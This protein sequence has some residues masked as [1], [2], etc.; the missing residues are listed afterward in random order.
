MGVFPLILILGCVV[1][2]GA[3]LGRAWAGEPKHSLLAG[4][5]ASA[6]GATT[7]LLTLL[8]PRSAMGELGHGDGMGLIGL[9]FFGAIGFGVGGVAIL[10]S[11]IVYLVGRDGRARALKEK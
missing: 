2:W 1:F 11:T 3:G 5:A 6:V 7:V 8:L 4:G 10:I 9:I